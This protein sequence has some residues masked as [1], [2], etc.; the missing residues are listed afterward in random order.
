VQHVRWPI[1]QAR[2][3]RLVYGADDP[4][5]VPSAPVSKS[6]PTCASTISEVTSGILAA[7]LRDYL[8]S[9]FFRTPVTQA[10]ARALR[11]FR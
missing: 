5:A 7:D 9:F 3:P 8:Q 1:I 6:S 2:V 11:D 10:L 4:K